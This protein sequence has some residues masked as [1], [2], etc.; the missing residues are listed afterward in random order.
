MWDLYRSLKNH[1]IFVLCKYFHTHLYIWCKWRDFIAFTHWIKANRVE[2]KQKLDGFFSLGQI[3]LLLSEKKNELDFWLARLW[4]T[5]DGFK[6]N[7]SIHFSR[8]NWTDSK[9]TFQMVKMRLFFMLKLA[10]GL[11]IFGFN[12]IVFYQKR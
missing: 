1:F 8:I 3:H 2:G 11:M 6:W 5:I 4:T 7:K 9:N 12:I 10:A